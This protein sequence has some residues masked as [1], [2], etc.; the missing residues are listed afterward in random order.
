MTNAISPSL[1]GML[2]LPREF[3]VLN[4][5]DDSIACGFDGESFTVPAGDE[6]L[7]PD[8]RNPD[9]PHSGFNSLGEPIPGSLIVRDKIGPRAMCDGGRGDGWSAAQALTHCLGLDPKTGEST[10]P[11]AKK[12]LSLLPMN[13]DPQLVA[14]TRSAGRERYDVFMLSWAR[15]HVNG[16]NERQAKHRSLGLYPEPLPQSYERAKALLEKASGGKASKVEALDEVMDLV[17]AFAQQ[18]AEKRPDLD[19]ESI[20]ERIKSDEAFMRKLKNQVVM[21]MPSKKPKGQEPAE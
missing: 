7:A 14:A 9:V 15:E 13:P 16:Y 11:Y 10:G 21:A 2:Q 8:P 20:V 19:M 6:I 12:G 18:A 4:P 1:L 5:T 3:L 17:H